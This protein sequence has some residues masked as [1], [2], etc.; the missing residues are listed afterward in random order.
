[1]EHLADEE[2]FTTIDPFDL[3]CYTGFPDQHDK[4]GDRP[5][6]RSGHIASDPNY[7]YSWNSKSQGKCVAYEGFSS[8]GAS[9][10]PIF[11]PPRGM[12]NIPNSR[13]GY[14]IGINAGHIPGSDGHSGISY[15]YKSTVI[16]N[17]IEKNKL[18][19]MINDCGA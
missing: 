18:R 6:I 13:H 3:V 12:S 9:G 10:G 7:D 5:I 2:I 1:M 14:L 16:L 19:N 11:S 8:G 17:I 4:L 15:F